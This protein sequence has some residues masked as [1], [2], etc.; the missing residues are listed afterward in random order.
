LKAELQRRETLLACDDRDWGEVKDAQLV[1]RRLR[2]LSALKE[3]RA[4]IAELEV[5]LFDKR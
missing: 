3:L 4:R 2:D 5:S 1:E